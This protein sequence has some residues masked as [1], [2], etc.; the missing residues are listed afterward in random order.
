MIIAIDG[1]KRTFSYRCS[2]CGKLCEGGPSFASD[3]PVQAF[4]VPEEEKAK[5]VRLNSDLCVLDDEHYFIRAT[6]DVPIIGSDDTFLWGVWVSQSK[7]NFDRYVKTFDED[8]SGDGSFGWLTVTMRGYTKKGE[9]M[10]ILPTNVHW[11]AERPEVRIHDDQDHPL[12]VDQREGISWD[13]AVEL[14]V[15]LCERK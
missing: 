2:C 11:G 7:E 15:L 9:A 13:R 12:A 10:V 14:A 1:E 8:Q 6:L 5:R 4:A 3:E